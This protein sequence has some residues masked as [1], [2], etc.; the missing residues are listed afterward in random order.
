MGK[1]SL[2]A[3]PGET[4]KGRYIFFRQR[5]FFA[6]SINYNEQKKENNTICN[7]INSSLFDKM[8]VGCDVFCWC[9]CVTHN[10]N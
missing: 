7:S 2:E 6:I 1:I 10:A 3:I 5:F 4:E 8:L 9:C